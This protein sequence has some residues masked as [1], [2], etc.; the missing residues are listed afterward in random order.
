M[1]DTQRFLAFLAE[2]CRGAIPFER[3]MKEAL[4]HP[5]FGY[6]SANIRT[7]GRRGD[8]STVPTWSRF[9][10]HALTQWI[11]SASCK[12]QWSVIEL[13]GGTGKLA[14][15]ILKA[16]GWW[17]RRKLTYKIVE[18]SQ[19]LIQEQKRRLAH[20][21][22]IRW[23]SNIAEALE[24]CG[25]RALIFSNEFVDAFPVRLFRKQADEWRECALQWEN[26]RLEEI[27]IEASPPGSS[28]VEGIHCLPEGSK[29]EVAETYCQWLVGWIP[30]WK[31]G[32]FLTIDYGNLFPELYYR[33]P[34]G[35]LRAFFHHHLIQGREIYQR[36]GYQDLTADVNFSDLIAWGA[37]LGLGLNSFDSLMEWL[38]PWS[39][40]A[41]ASFLDPNGIGGSFKVLCQT[42]PSS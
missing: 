26:Q 7:V 15:G 27:W 36:F 32:Q 30:F 19:P 38:G 22:Q 24:S 40:Q 1:T 2:S 34:F 9:L 20:Y 37:A 29:I 8:F 28:A 14:E 21:S 5:E 11:V 41:P 12:E 18:I 25:G 39:H 23:Y 3:F 16:L 31:A 17:K 42:C 35:T 4:F 10:S 33:R 13:G 6:Y